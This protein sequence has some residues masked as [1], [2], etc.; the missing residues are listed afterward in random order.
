ML[1][2]CYMEVNGFPNFDTT[3]FL[4][5]SAKVRTFLA[6]PAKSGIFPEFRLPEEQPAWI[7][8][9]LDELQ[10]FE[11]VNGQFKQWGVSFN[12]A[13]ALNPSN[14]AFPAHTGTLL[15]MAAPK[16]GFIEAVFEHPV[17]YVSGLVTS[18]RRTVLSAYDRD[19][20]LIAQSEIP[21]GNLAG[22][23]SEISPNAPLSVSAENIYRVTFYAFDAQL[24]VDGFGFCL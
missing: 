8:L 15:L 4:I 12:N 19:N 23:D 3:E 10:C 9:K 21:G 7:A 13:I 16:S 14:P 24:T 11:A 20:N 1:E 2:P 22:T 5:D 17:R 6:S 18:S